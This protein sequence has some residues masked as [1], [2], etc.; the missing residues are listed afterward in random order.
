MTYFDELPLNDDIL[1][2]L[3]DMNF[4]E[5]TPIQELAI[6]KIFSGCDLIASAQTGTGK[7]A[8]YLLPIIEKISSGVLDKNRVNALILVPT[9]ELAQQVDQLMAGFAYYL[10]ITWIAIFG[11]N[12][13]VAFSQQQKALKDGC[14]IVVAT[15]GRL[16]SFLRTC[17]IDFSAID[18]LVLDEADRMLDI[19]FYDDIMEIV[20]YINHKCQT[21][22]F[23]ATYPKTVEKLAMK[24]L[25]N[26]EQVKISVSKP[27]DGISQNIFLVNDD[28][29]QKL[30]CAI[31]KSQ[32][33]K[34]TIIFASSKQNVKDLYKQLIRLNFN[35]AQIH[36]DLDNNTRSEVILNFKNGKVDLLVATDV[37]ARGIDIENVEVV[38]NYD[39]PSHPEDYVHRVGR[40]ARAGATGVAYTFVNAKDKLRMAKIESFIDKSIPRASVTE[41]LKNA[42]DLP[43]DDIEQIRE[44][45]KSR[46]N[47]HHGYRQKSN[48]NSDNRSYYKRNNSKSGKNI[49]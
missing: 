46:K 5:C 2:A 25:H 11:G 42:T 23:S 16:I 49:K 47:Y 38:V 39:V 15:P 30:L 34:K 19:G 1:D 31:A 41:F 18:M 21:L 13:G 28:L 43:V 33:W 26:P 29:K 20:K 4:V 45:R 44:K 12:D 36:S 24:I 37:V 48:K 27:A 32:S 40:T 9:R 6:P 8:A 35:V 14:D 3:D 17:N 22:L 7:T 10:N